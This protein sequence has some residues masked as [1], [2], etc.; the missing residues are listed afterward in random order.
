VFLE[1][2]QSGCDALRLELFQALQPFPE[3]E[4]VNVLVLRVMIARFSKKTSPD[5]IIRLSE[6]LQ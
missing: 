2:A 6:L 1:S 3:E 4:I 5:R